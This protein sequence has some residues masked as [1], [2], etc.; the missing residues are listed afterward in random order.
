MAKAKT[1]AKAVG[2]PRQWDSVEEMSEAIEAY[3]A[4]CDART[5][6]TIVGKEL[7]DVAKSEP[8]TVQ[9]LAVALNL[10]TKGLIGYEE[11]EEFGATIKHARARI[12]ANKVMHML[13]G[14]GY[15]PGYIFDLKHNYGWKDKQELDV[16]MLNSP[17]WLEIQQALILVLQAHPEALEDTK[18]VLAKFAGKGEN[19]RE[20]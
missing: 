5:V 3:F 16:N 19:A 17:A 4:K 18:K 8:Y 1:E 10:T 9:G 2:A 7:V 20:R 11:R 15:G 13:D 12:E 6:A 14:D